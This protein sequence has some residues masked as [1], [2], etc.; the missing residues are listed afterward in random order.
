MPLIS[1]LAPDT[2]APDY[3]T[4][5]EAIGQGAA[6][7]TEVSH[8]GSLPDLKLI[9]KS[10]SKLLVVDGEELAGRSRTE[11][12]TAPFSLPARPKSQYPSAAWSREG[13]LIGPRSLP[14]ERG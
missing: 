5:E 11:S 7:V 6:D 13:G 1:L 8:G 10:A 3:L 14:M 9:N 2:G 4:L 12:L